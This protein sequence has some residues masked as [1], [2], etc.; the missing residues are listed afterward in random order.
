M[1]LQVRRLDERIF[2]QHWATLKLKLLVH[3]D[4][5]RALLK[6]FLQT[7]LALERPVPREFVQLDDEIRLSYRW[8]TITKRSLILNNTDNLTQA[9][10]SHL[11]RPNR[12]IY[13]R[14][15]ALFNMIL[16]WAGYVSL[17]CSV[18]VASKRGEQS[19]NLHLNQNITWTAHTYLVYYSPIQAIS[20]QFVLSS[21][22]TFYKR[23]NNPFLIFSFITL[24]LGRLLL[25]QFDQFPLGN[26]SC[27]VVIVNA[28]KYCLQFLTTSLAGRGRLVSNENNKRLNDVVILRG[29]F[30][31]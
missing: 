30:W 12:S 11:A 5:L 22:N 18:T 1:K 26:R 8:L 10:I 28:A 7:W 6:Y 9:K 24:V 4:F 3:T 25:V 19:N 21:R 17:T 31:F 29:S 27:Q 15:H 13:T 14:T 20:K 16:T 2:S 23:F